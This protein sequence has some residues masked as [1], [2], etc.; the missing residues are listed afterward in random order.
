[1]TPPVVYAPI[2]SSPKFSDASVKIV[3]NDDK[4]FKSFNNITDDTMFA[5]VLESAKSIQYYNDI[6]NLS[7]GEPYAL[8][9]Y[10][11][12]R[13]FDDG[14]A[15]LFFSYDPQNATDYV[16]GINI[17]NGLT[18]GAIIGACH[19]LVPSIMDAR[20]AVGI[21]FLI[22]VVFGTIVGIANGFLAGFIAKGFENWFQDPT[23]PT[24]VASYI[25]VGI[26][27]IIAGCIFG[28]YWHLSKGRIVRTAGLSKRM[29][30]FWFVIFLVI[31]YIFYPQV[32]IYK[33]LVPN[34][35]Y[36]WADKYQTDQCNVRYE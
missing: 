5:D 19:E 35:A 11:S 1:M 25:V 2:I 32:W 12:A 15:L 14:L 7:S 30:I 8:G 6:Y 29:T 16:A 22:W 31:F 3:Q 34:N 36:S 27:A 24:L 4:T 33:S 28:A 10:T 13:Q 26:C 23:H 18:L 20:C 21:W 9:R 17:L